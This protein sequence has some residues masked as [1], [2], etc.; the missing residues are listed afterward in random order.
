MFVF[1][2][3]SSPLHSALFFLPPFYTFILVLLFYLV[4][5][6][7]TSITCVTADRWKSVLHWLR[8]KDKLL[9]KFVL[10]YQSLEQN[11]VMLLTGVDGVSC[12]CILYLA[13]NASD[14]TEFALFV[15]LKFKE[16]I[17][18]LY[19]YQNNWY[20]YLTFLF[21]TLSCVLDFL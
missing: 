13:F 20:I 7:V 21:L 8:Y 17:N 6:V 9:E 1:L 4:D 5:L 3:T 18:I 19:H 10:T 11:A 12:L 14:R 15:Y 16:V 2:A